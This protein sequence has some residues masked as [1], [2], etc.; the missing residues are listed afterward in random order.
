[1]PHARNP[2]FTGREGVL[3]KLHEAL[4]SG[5]AAALS[6]PQAISGLGGIGKTQT[7]VEYAYRYRE[8]YSAVLWVRADSQESLI[9]SFVALAELL[10]LPGKDEQDQQAVVA[11]V[12]RW[13]QTAS[14]W[15]LIFDNA[16]NLASVHPFL[17]TEHKGHILLTTRAQA[18][19]TLAQRIE[20]GEMSPEEGGRFLLRRAG[21]HSLTAA[22]RQLAEQ[23]SRTLGGLPLALDQAG[24]FIEETPSSLSEYLGLYKQEGVRLLAERGELAGDH[25]SVTV[26]FSLAFGQVAAR[27]PAAAD[28]LRLCAFLAPEAI[29]EEIFTEGAEELGEVFGPKAK[30]AFELAKVIREAG[31]FSLIERDA[32]RKTLTIHRLVQT[33]LQD[34]MDGDIQ[35]LWAERAVGA[36]NEAFPDVEVN[37]WPRCER[38]LP[39]A[40]VCAE[41]ITRWNLAFPEAAGLLN[42]AGAYLHDRARYQ[43]AEPLYQRALAIR[44]QVLGPEH[45]DVATSL[46]DLALLYDSQGRYRHAEPLYQRALA[47]YKKVLGPEHTDVATILNNLN[48]TTEDSYT[49]SL[50]VEPLP[51]GLSVAERSRRPANPRVTHSSTPPLPR[52]RSERTGGPALKKCGTVPMSCGSI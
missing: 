19:G 10:A 12:K 46:N 51:F 26:T 29:P 31:R 44:E 16:D 27:D 36:V 32:E 15:L 8:T 30:S 3:K 11:V 20:I 21:I 48:Q 39:H 5:N 33:V 18:T 38:F 23:I 43:E 42:Q 17:P 6:Q 45:P 13:L 14:N 22:D 47:I 1:V 25:A 40:Q 52:L 34:E 4:T 9:S 2:F 50:A 37:T 28:L 41:L 7:A 35:R 49:S 24:A